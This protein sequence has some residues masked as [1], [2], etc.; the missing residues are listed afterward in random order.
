MLILEKRISD[1]HLE[2]REQREQSLQKHREDSTRL[3]GAVPT[4]I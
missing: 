3:A 2:G 4:R 1:G